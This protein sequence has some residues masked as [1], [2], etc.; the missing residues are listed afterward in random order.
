ML[1]LGCSGRGFESR[2]LYKNADIVQWLVYEISNLEMSV[3]FWLSAQIDLGPLAQ[4]AR[5]PALHAGGRE[6]ESRRV[7]GN[8]CLVR[9]CVLSPKS[10]T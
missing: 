5:A 8:S 2:L 4:M 10:T 6:F 1:H 9:V 7:H 3:R